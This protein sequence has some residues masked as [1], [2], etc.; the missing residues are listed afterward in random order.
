MMDEPNIQ[1]VGKPMKLKAV[2]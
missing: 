2:C 1:T